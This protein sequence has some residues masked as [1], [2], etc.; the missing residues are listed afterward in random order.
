MKNFPRYKRWGVAVVFVLLLCVWG[1]WSY[2]GYLVEVYQN[3]MGQKL[4][5]QMAGRLRME[6]EMTPNGSLDLVRSLSELG[7]FA[8][9]RGLPIKL[10]YLDNEGFMLEYKPGFKNRVIFFKEIEGEVIVSWKRG[11]DSLTVE[12]SLPSP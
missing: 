2:Y 9:H 10:V 6:L 8:D 1:S 7:A 12:S 4:V 5:E 11:M 3:R